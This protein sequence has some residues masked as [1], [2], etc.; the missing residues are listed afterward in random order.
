MSCRMVPAQ[1]TLN[2]AVRSM[3]EQGLLVLTPPGGKACQ[4]L[5]LSGPACAAEKDH[6]AGLSGRKSMPAWGWS[7]WNR[8]QTLRQD[9]CRLR[10]EFTH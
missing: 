8:P 5:N 10:E 1:Q 2:S 4:E 6:S 9:T 7:A 3:V